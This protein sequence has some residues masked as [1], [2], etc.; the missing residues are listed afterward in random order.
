ML[1]SSCEGEEK[2]SGPDIG[3]RDSLP[4]LK[5][6]G[7]STVISDSGIIRYKI[8]SEDWYMYDKTDPT[9]WSFEKGLFLEKFD[10]NY[11]VEAFINCD[12]AYFYDQK[13]LWE[14]RGRVFMKNPKGDTFRTELL[15]WDQN[16]HEFYSPAYMEV[17]GEEQSLRGT[18]FRSNEDMTRYSIH[19]SSGA[20]PLEE[21]DP[22]ERREEG[23]NEEN[24]K[25]QS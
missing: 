12:T 9:Y 4:F 19:Y 8:I 15:Y 6:L 7:V 21:D 5:S 18:D 10:E 24:A 1:F 16:L 23:M 14:L 25:T 22:Q 2:A 11:K 13:R 3:V 20:F 17:E